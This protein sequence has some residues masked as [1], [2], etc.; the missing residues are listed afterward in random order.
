VAIKLSA[1][2]P[3][4]SAYPK[5]LVTFGDHLRKARLDRGLLQEEVARALEADKDTITK[6]ENGKASP[7]LPFIPRILKF[8]GYNP[9]PPAQTLPKKLVQSRK[10]L[11]ITQKA[12]ARIFH[13]SQSTLAKWE[14]EK[15]EPSK[16]SRKVIKS[17]LHDLPK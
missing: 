3:K 2:K 13:V 16:R 6:W 8:L 1:E 12:Q 9:F 15:A 4:S 11:G 17:F 14:R 10:V 5:V 7:S